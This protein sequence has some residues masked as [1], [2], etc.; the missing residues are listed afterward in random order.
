MTLDREPLLIRSDHSR[1]PADV[2]LDLDAQHSLAP[3]WN[4]PAPDSSEA[5]VLLAEADR[6]DGMRVEVYINNDRLGRLTAADTAEFPKI[7]ASAGADGSPVV[8]RAIR[9]RDADGNWALHIYRPE[10]S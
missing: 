8:G 9:D 4:Q 5:F 6:G 3:T 1:P 2:M 10:P 7:V